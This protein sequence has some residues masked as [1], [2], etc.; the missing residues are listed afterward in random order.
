MGTAH[1]CDMHSFQAA[2]SMK[3]FSP[4]LRACTMRACAHMSGVDPPAYAYPAGAISHSTVSP[5]KSIGGWSSPN[6]FSGILHDVP[7][8]PNK[9]TDLLS[10]PPHS[11]LHGLDLSF[12]IP[13]HCILHEIGATPLVHIDSGIYAKLEGFN[14]SGSI[15]D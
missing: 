14:P 10:L 3:K 1:P 9:D 11:I 5:T 7:Q 6:N 2:A 12:S 13:R 15:K 8:E 4:T